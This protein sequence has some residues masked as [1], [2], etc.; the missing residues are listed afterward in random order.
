MTFAALLLTALLGS[1]Q[2]FELESP[3]DT[4]PEMRRWVRS[5]VPQRLSAEWRWR[6]MS[7]ALL[8]MPGWR[9]EPPGRRTATAIEAF[10][11]RRVNCVAFSHLA[12]ALAREVGVEASFVMATD[13]FGAR[14][15]KGWRIRERHLA[16]AFGSSE[17]LWVLDQDGFH[18]A[19]P[20][21]FEVVEDS[22]A[23]AIFHSNRGVEH[24]LEGDLAAAR[25]WLRRAVRI[26]PSLAQASNNLGVVERRL[27]RFG[28]P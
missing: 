18:A 15:R 17:R 6:R 21:E 27:E 10:V 13:G 16:A 12:V 20:G 4:T 9:I 5:H 14:R 19:R 8:E 7:E 24:L 28:E 1:A 11:S 22:T 3:L 2:P 25:D 23:L 26:D